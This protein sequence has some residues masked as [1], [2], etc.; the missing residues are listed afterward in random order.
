MNKRI[1]SFLLAILLVITLLPMQVWAAEL[2]NSSKAAED[3]IV[4]EEEAVIPPEEFTEESTEQTQEELPNEDLTE[5]E[6]PLEKL[7]ETSDENVEEPAAVQT[8]AANG[9][10]VEIYTADD[11]YR[12]RDNLAGNYTLMDDIDLSSWENWEPIGQEDAPFQ[13]TFDGNGHIIR[14]M[15]IDSTKTATEETHSYYY[16]LFGYISG[17]TISSVGVVN[18]TINV[19]YDSGTLDSSFCEVGGLAGYITKSTISKSF[20]IG[21]ITVSATGNTY[22]RVAGITA[23]AVGDSSI[24]DCFSNAHIKAE[25]EKMN[26]FAAGI[27]AYLDHGS[28]I[29]CYVTGTISAKDPGGYCYFGG[30]NASATRDTIWGIVLDYFG[31]VQKSVV[32]LLSVE[33]EGARVVQDDIGKLSQNS[34]CKVLDVT[35]EEV[36]TQATYTALGWDFTNTWKMSRD[37]PCLQYHTIAPTIFSAK[38]DGWSF[39]N[40][41]DGF[42][43]PDDYS[44]PEER[45]A[46]V[47]GSSYVAAAK[48]AGDE[49]LKSMMPKW[50]GGCAGMGLAAVQFFN[51]NFL[52]NDYIPNTIKT[53]NQYWDNASLISAG[54][55]SKITQQIERCSIFINHSDFFLD[56]GLRFWTSGINDYATK[57]KHQIGGVTDHFFYAYWHNPDGAYISNILTTI[58]NSSTP[59]LISLYKN[60]GAHIVVTR[61]DKRPQTVDGWTRVYIYD[62]NNPWIN[63]ALSSYVD[64]ANISYALNN[65]NE[66]RYIELNADTNQWRYIGSINNAHKDDYWGSDAEGVVQYIINPSDSDRDIIYPEFLYLYNAEYPSS[67]D[68]TAPWMRRY[69]DAAR[70][71]T[72]PNST[73]SVISS[74]GDKLCQVENGELTFSL[75]PVRYC[76]YFNYMDGVEDQRSGGQLIIP[77]TEFTIQYESGDDISIIGDDDVINIATDGRMVLD[78]STEENSIKVSGGDTADIAVQITDVYNNADYTSAEVN[79]KLA[80][81]DGFSMSLTNDELNISGDLDNSQLTVYTDNAEQPE[82]TELGKVSGADEDMHVPDVRKAA[83]SIRNFSVTPEKLL[84]TI[85]EKAALAVTVSDAIAITWTS[86]DPQI[87]SVDEAGIV[88]GVANGTAIITATV[89][90]GYSASCQVTVAPPLMGDV[91]RD[92]LVNVFDVQR[93]Y[94]HLIGTNPIEDSQQLNIADINNDDAINVYDLQQLYEIVAET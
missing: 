42:S 33:V 86:S 58:E 44:I 55:D 43:Y 83:S 35:S 92:R 71:L 9:G 10:Y 60:G 94:E 32:M 21:S 89:K 88:T 77:A 80:S 66:D 74:D 81:G 34:S 53:A 28:V 2:A 11:L 49:I 48:L 93:L 17:G 8:Q 61:T 72:S 7:P 24:V 76:S 5:E 90:G 27:A 64:I 47:L 45:Y 67:F 56:N 54:K 37:F 46:E 52:L 59:L 1:V 31:S 4:F 40:H 85:G 87:A 39:V 69:Q 12:I 79:G 22:V 3:E 75:D 41:W 50:N 15:K 29:R 73:F 30:I 16:G 63:E 84:L 13:G 51:G 82:A 19:S 36:S 20:F 62:P 68:G 57:T 14:N 91:N 78:I 18:A 70:L 65:L 25:A 23:E 38:R 26:L 6:K